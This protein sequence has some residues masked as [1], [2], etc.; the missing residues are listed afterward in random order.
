MKRRTCLMVLLVIL[1][2][3]VSVPAAA[4]ERLAV[5][6]N[7]SRV[8]YFDGVERVAVANPEI[9]D[10]VVVSGSEILLV[11]KNPG[12]TTLHVWSRTGRTSYVVEA[13]ADDTMLA[14]NI[15]NILR[16]D[17]IRV[18]KVNNTVILEGTVNDQYQRSRAEKVAAA[19]GDKVVNMLEIT[20]PMQVKIE[21]KVIE[22]NREKVKNLGIKWGND[23]AIPGTFIFGQSLSDPITGDVLGKWGGYAGINGELNALIKDGHAKLLSQPNIITLSGEKANIV[24]GGEIPVPVGIDNNRVSIEWKQYGIKLNIAPEVTAGSL[25]TS[26]VTAE[27]STLDWNSTHKIELGLGMKIPPIK[28]R[29]AESALALSS[30]QT[31]AIGGLIAHETARDVH[32][33]PLLANI[34]VIG[35]LF[36]SSSFTRGETEL[37]ILITPTIV[38]PAEYLPSVTPDMAVAATEN[39]WGGKANVQD[40]S[41]GR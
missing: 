6:V 21:A 5:A 31:M 12:H 38:D 24:V 15:K 13:A 34:P 7:H 1:I 16:Y 40:K 3:A 17:N 19:Y 10:V 23:P 18:S 25:V 22:I 20:N 9:A 32:K 41:A 39:P 35:N 28:L 27:V 36:K 30:G 11:G 29:K 4:A 33:V 14:A 8:L 26:R 2:L 37:L